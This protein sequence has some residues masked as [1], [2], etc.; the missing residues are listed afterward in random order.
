MKLKK[1]IGFILFFF[2]LIPQFVF[3]D[4]APKNL[5]KIQ[6]II[7]IYL[8]NHSFDNLYGFFPNADGIKDAGHYALQIDL[9]GE[10]YETLPTVM[11]GS[12]VDKRFPDKLANRPFNINNYIGQNE[13]IGDLVHRFYQH[14]MQINQGQMNRFAAVSN[15][16]GLT[17]GYFDGKQLPLWQ[18]AKRF[19]LADHFFQAAF[20]GSFLNHQWLVC[21]CTPFY[22]NAPDSLK[23]ELDEKGKLVKDAPLTPDGYAVNTMQPRQKPHNV[24]EDP[25]HYLP[26]QTQP[27]IGDKLSEK[28]ISWAWYAGGWNDA[29]KGKP[30]K[31]FQFHHQPF[32]YFKQYAEGTTARTEHLKDETDFLKGIE[33]GVLPAVSFFKPIGDLTEH[34]GYADVLSGDQHIA[35]ILQKIER[36]RLW[37][38]SVVIVTYDEFGGFWDHVPPPVIDRWG[39]GNRVPA[40]IVSPFAK[41]GFVDHTV[42]DTTSILKL[43]EAR[44][45][46]SSLTERDRNAT[47]LFNA[48]NL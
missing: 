6:H 13:K 46:L 18:Y 36:S 42:Y 16:G 34:P 26:E 35:D 33:K 12:Q 1:L 29:A 2:V 30:S 10:P 11:N 20:G 14:Q 7:V 27:T 45:A 19:T 39:V 40:I 4:K 48:L 3:A 5:N 41:Q 25:K 28:N 37:K 9:D 22:E 38:D 43:I 24:K 17:M 8:E 23:A 32:V 15:A 31:Q 44:F 21:A 47:A